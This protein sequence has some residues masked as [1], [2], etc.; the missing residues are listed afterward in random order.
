MARYSDSASPD[1]AVLIETDDFALVYDRRN[2][3]FHKKR[4]DSST[5]SWTTKVAPYSALVAKDGSTVWAEDASGKTIASGEA[6]VDDA[7][8][9]QSVVNALN[10]R[11]KIVLIG[12]FILNNKIT[13][14][15]DWLFFEGQPAKLIISTTDWAF[16]LWD[17]D[18]TGVSPEYCC[19]KDLIIEG[20]TGAEKIFNL[21]YNANTRFIGIKASNVAKFL[22]LERTWG[23]NQLMFNCAITG[24]PPDG[25]GLIEVVT[26]Q[27]DLSDA[28]HF[29]HNSFGVGNSKA[30]VFNLLHDARHFVWLDNCF[31][32]PD[33][34]YCIR[35]AS[36]ATMYYCFLTD[37]KF[38][39]KYAIFCEG[40]INETKIKGG[41]S[42]RLYISNCK[43]LSVENV[44]FIFNGAVSEPHFSD[45]GYGSDDPTI[46]ILNG[47][48]IR[49]TN[50][51]FKMGTTTSPPLIHLGYGDGSGSWSDVKISNMILNSDSVAVY[52]VHARDSGKGL[53][54]S[55]VTFRDFAGNKAW[56]ATPRAFAIESGV[57]DVVLDN[58]EFYEL[59]VY[60]PYHDTAKTAIQEGRVKIEN[61]AAPDGWCGKNSGVA[62][63]SGDGTTTQFSIAH[64]LVSTPTKVQVTPMSSDAAADF[65]VTADDTNIYIN[66]KSAPPSGTDNLKF[67]WYAEV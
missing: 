26:P 22:R 39:G 66:Y 6:G 23:D 21:R 46:A 64:G 8:V 5:K 1:E 41:R 2:R 17:G 16:E 27:N 51:S 9:I 33:I 15:K 12:D 10:E 57:S 42:T 43:D 54:V 19:F 11:S 48:N 67:S 56:A 59:T 3:A 20:K 28:W 45:V 30:Y 60:E 38:E 50:L 62:T 49:L 25:E 7:S 61:T 36:G 65:Y 13:I 47:S 40:N 44:E 52:F 18:Y 58:V 53:Y 34:E 35:V 14:T 4:W 55:N 32:Y 31:E 24:N 37:N 29:I 63:F